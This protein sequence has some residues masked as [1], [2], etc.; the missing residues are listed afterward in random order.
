MAAKHTAEVVV[1][2]RKVAVESILKV[3]GR[4]RKGETQYK[5]ASV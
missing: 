4:I 3:E 1:G 5:R 2:A